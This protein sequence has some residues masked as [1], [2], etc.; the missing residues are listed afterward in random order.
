[1]GVAVLAW[2][3]STVTVGAAGMV[4]VGMVMVGV[5]VGT[6]DGDGAEIS[7]LGSMAILIGAGVILTDILMA[8]TLT[9]RLNTM[10][11]T[12]RYITAVSCTDNSATVRTF[13][14]TNS[15]IFSTS[16]N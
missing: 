3:L 2:R 14:R 4:M 11:G 13:N 15:L 5:G 6:R 16:I 10:V 7:P 1:M 8:T 9:R 12:S